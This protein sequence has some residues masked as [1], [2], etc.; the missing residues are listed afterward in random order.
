[1]RCFYYSN[2]GSVGNLY[3]M[4]TTNLDSSDICL[5]INFQQVRNNLIFHKLLIKNKDIAWLCLFNSLICRFYFLVV[6][7]NSVFVIITL[8]KTHSLLPLLSAPYNPE[9]LP[10]GSP[11]YVIG[12]WPGDG[13]AAPRCVHHRVLPSNQIDAGP[14]QQDHGMLEGSDRVAHRQGPAVPRGHPVVFERCHQI[15]R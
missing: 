10:R 6:K 12:R 11:D 3:R 5:M 4:K 9:T 1:M 15:A 14:L 8:C 2:S 7:I 13:S